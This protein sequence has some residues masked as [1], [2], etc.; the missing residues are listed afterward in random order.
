MLGEDTPA[1]LFVVAADNGALKN[2]ISALRGGSGVRF[3]V[4]VFRLGTG[5]VN[6]FITA[7]SDGDHAAEKPA[8]VATPSRQVAGHLQRRSREPAESKD[9]R[10]GSDASSERDRAARK[11]ESQSHCRPVKS[12]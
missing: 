7:R 5:I 8:R 4:Y 3:V 1:S 11:A 9:E 12:A 2:E 10:T 6:A